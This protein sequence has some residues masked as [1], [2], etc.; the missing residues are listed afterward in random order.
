MRIDS[1]LKRALNGLFFNQCRKERPLP[2]Q[3]APSADMV[4]APPP[5]PPRDGDPPNP[6]ILGQ[7][8]CGGCRRRHGRD[9]K[10]Q[11]KKQHFVSRGTTVLLSP[12]ESNFPRLLGVTKQALHLSQ[13]FFCEPSSPP[14]QRV[15]TQ[16]RPSTRG[17][18]PP[19]K[20]NTYVHP[21]VPTGILTQL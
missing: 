18:S 12:I 13:F 21:E 10:G 5:P 15:G 1:G 14:I 20:S 11:K 3:V 9:A 6:A 17:G 16:P 19:Q 2:P 7:T 4:V 8:L